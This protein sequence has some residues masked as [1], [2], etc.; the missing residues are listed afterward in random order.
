MSYRQP[1]EIKTLQ[2]GLTYVPDHAAKEFTLDTG[3]GSY[4]LKPHTEATLAEHRQRNRALA[5]LSDE[6]LRQ[7]THF[8]EEVALPA[9]VARFLR[10]THDLAGA[11]LP[12]LACLITYI[13]AEARLANRRRDLA[14]L[15]HRQPT[16][17]SHF[18]A[19]LPATEDLAEEDLLALWADADLVNA[20]PLD[21]ARSLTF[22]HPQLAT[23]N[24]ETA[25]VIVDDHI[26][27]TDELLAFATLISSL[28]EATEKGGWATI[29]PSVDKDGKP[30]TWGPGYEAEGHPEGSTVY[31]YDLDNKIAGTA[32]EPP[33]D[34]SGL[35]TVNQAL[36]TSQDDTRL[37]NQSW[38][39]LQ[40]TPDVRQSS[41][42]TATRFAAFQAAAPEAGEFTFTL[43]NRT[44]GYGLSVPK[45]SLKFIP[46][47]NDP[48]KG[49]L[50][51][52]AKNKFLR[53]LS[54]YVQFLD[55]EGKPI[56]NPPGWIERL[57]ERLREIFE[58]PST[59]YIC[60]VSPV[61][62][63]FGIPLPT[64][65]TE[66][67]F[68][69]PETAASSQLLFGGIGTR[70][71]NGT[72]DPPGIILT[73]VFQ[74]GIPT[75]FLL[76]GGAVESNA[77]FK[78]FLSN[79]ENVITVLLAVFPIVGVGTADDPAL[80][81]TK[82]VL[83]NFAKAISGIIVDKGLE[84][85][86]E[87]ILAKL[88]AAQIVN[89]I[90][91]LGFAFRMANMVITFRNLLETTIEVAISPATYT[92]EVRRQLALELT[93]SPD[94]LHGIWPQVATSYVAVVQYR[95][96]TNFTVT[97][98]LPEKRDQPVVVS[99]PELPGGGQFQVVFG[100]YSPTQFLAGNW[101]SSWVDA[102][103]P[104]GSDGVLKLQGQIQER[105]VPLSPDTQ[106]LH[107]SKLAYDSRSGRHVWR[108]GDQP[109]AVITDL[110]GGSTGHNLAEPV[111]ITLNNKAHLLGYSWQASGQRL[112][113][114]G[115]PDPT[116]GQIY[117]FQNI[118]ILAD[119]EAALKFPSCG[120]SAQSSLVYDQFGPAPRFS[121]D[122]SVQS[123]LDQGKITP[124]LRAAFA[125]NG[126]ALPAN[127]RVQVE[128]ATVRW[129][130]F[131]GLTDPTYDLRREA[132]G[133][134]SVFSYPTPVLSLNNFYVDPRSG[135]YHLRRV[136][137]DDK[138]PF[139][140]NNPGLSYG[141]FTQP[142]LDSIVVH[143]AGYV[144]GVNFTNHKMEIIQIPAEGIPDAKAQ[145]AAMVSG[146]G[147]RQGLMNGPIA[148]AVAADGRLLVLEGLNQRIQAF[149]LNGNPVA[150]F[151]GGNLATLD[152]A[153]APALDQG[154]A[155]MA[156]RDAF[157]AAGAVL[158]SH[159]TIT[160]G[161]NQYDIQ[162]DASGRLNLQ[163]NGADLSSQWL[164]R[165]ANGD[166]PVKAETGRLV[167]QVQ[168]PFDL[169]LDDR[170]LLDRGG[171][172]EEIVA[173]FAAHGIELSRQADVTGDGLHVPG[174]YQV[175]LA[176]GVI[177]NDLKAAYATR[178][179][180][181]T[182]QAVLTSRVVVRVQTP[183]GLWI[184]D[185]TD[186]TQAYRISRDDQDATKL[187]AIYWNP[188][189]SLRVPDPAEEVTYLDLAV[190]MQG[191]LYVLSYTG[192]GEAVDDYKLDLYDPLGH[193][194]SRTPDRAKDPNAKGVN[195]ARLIVD[196]FR[197]MYTLNFEHFLGPN[198]R[199]EP[200]V[201]TWLPTTPK[202]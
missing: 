107:D 92:V 1:T 98:D 5:L 121:L 168:P 120:F 167:V 154:L 116:N 3:D 171:V 133:R 129:L 183:G 63:I 113:F 128:Q 104:S 152:G 9:D 146:R 55:S 175:D 119:P 86:A 189:L 42:A 117:T 40:G 13:P 43:N 102:V 29:R 192:E 200:S 156:L 65:P 51:I 25:A 106:Y 142:N 143:P 147:S 115:F 83:S 88:T 80:G 49:Q 59:K 19:M 79:L 54:A 160:D 198:D 164:I 148:V 61:E 71:W 126:Y 15:R 190:E 67:A 32:D 177:S 165:D 78:D 45:E 57:P 179:V 99:F 23:R 118:S 6:Q 18:G 16:V 81:N 39:V 138:T 144:V 187:Q 132:T 149:D 84:K 11:P 21:V 185:D 52:D 37:E 69:F 176:Q 17:L 173:A 170:I 193:F 35:G 4:V 20:S 109:T 100:V 97:G 62:V 166:Y 77:F 50:S 110:D 72:V 105:L 161:P 174:S 85:L 58:T 178:G 82:K 157:A 93:V 27:T 47:P 7:I 2:F 24:A 181:I 184:V 30:L 180:V 38:S 201:S 145:P 36:R 96:G 182:D 159:W 75:L 34:S 26:D 73:G 202:G 188:T 112:P 155:T 134:I 163:Q 41:E 74:Y 153:L 76:G 60:S 12:A 186:A 195:G 196:M 169:P 8:S 172:T 197:S 56:D 123:G 124:E 14:R 95:N 108:K 125:A 158:S 141:Y 150:S 64:D 122:S 70:N 191:F 127:A 140:P 135:L 33:G 114:C 194:L 89:A 53:T 22:S 101:V 87:H 28:G 130:I 103:A 151:D 136:V 10:V 48:R 131:T 199:T 94:P 31:Y 162:L 139:D 68:P 111:S 66:L 90:P 91:I 46:D 137:L 44:P